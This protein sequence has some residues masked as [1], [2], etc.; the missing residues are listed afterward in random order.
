MRSLNLMIT[1]VCLCVFA[2]GLAFGQAISPGAANPQVQGQAS[3]V[4]ASQS[5]PLDIRW[6][7]FFR[8]LSHMEDAAKQ[9]EAGGNFKDASG[10]R[11]K[12]RRLAGLSEEEGTILA[13]LAI[14]CTQA[15]EAH[16]AKVTAFIQQRE[17]TH[18]RAELRR[19]P[20]PPELAQLEQQRIALVY[21]HVVALREKLGEVPFQKVNTYLQQQSRNIRRADPGAGAVKSADP[22]PTPVPALSQGVRND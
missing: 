17:A 19:D 16:Y 3:R 15:L 9:F 8:H 14:D 21:S 22:A 12:D 18:S 5:I 10:L 11:N 20:R 6:Q 2:F 13:Q 1:L 4:Q 7:I